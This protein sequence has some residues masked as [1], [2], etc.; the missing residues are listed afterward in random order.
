MT[1]TGKLLLCCLAA[2]LQACAATPAWQA[3]AAG[4]ADADADGV[5]DR[6]DQCPRTPPGARV[7]R[8]GCE[9]DSDCDGVADGLDR[10]PRTSPGASVD[11]GGCEPL[12]AA[13]PLIL[14]GV[15]FHTNS[16][17]L[18]GPALDLLDG[19]ARELAARP[20][21]RVEIAGHTD[22]RNTEDYNLDL[23]LRRARAV[24]VALAS[25][26][27]A[28]ERMQPRGYGESQPIAD[29]RTAEGMQR[30]RRVE[31]RAIPETP[32]P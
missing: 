18:T 12:L 22:A 31:L 15:N 19:V 11:A 29:N 4:A 3:G 2:G 23:S 30:N 10:C 25:R 20:Q 8:L 24:Q 32:A 16:D 9:L 27:I 21:L 14:Q 17:R 13:A 26:G 5:V 6:W 1:M 7:D 28:P